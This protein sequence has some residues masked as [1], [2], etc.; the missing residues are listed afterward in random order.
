MTRTRFISR[1]KR[2]HHPESGQANI[3]VLLALGIF[4]LAFIGLAVDYSFL[5]FHRQRAQTAADAA[6]QAGAMDMLVNATNDTSLG[7]FPSPI[8]DFDCASVPDAAPCKYAALNGH[9]STTLSP[10]V[11][12][13]L[14][15]VSFPASVDGITTPPSVL[16]PT[17]FIKVNVQDAAPVYFSS[18]ITGNRVQNVGATA[19][20]GLVQSQSPIPII[21]L[22]PT[23]Q[24]SF[25]VSGSA[26][27]KIVGGPTKSVQVNSGNQSCAAATNGSSNSC[28][29]NGTIDLSQ[30]GPDFNGSAF[31]VFG[32]PTTAPK[33]FTGASWSQASPINDPF[34]RVPAPDLN[35]LPVPP[36]NGTH[37]N[38]HEHGCPDNKGCTWYEAG[39]YSVPIAVKGVT[40]IFVPGVYYIKPLSYASATGGNLCG[41][42]GSGCTAGGGGSCRADF[43]VDANGVV[44]PSNDAG[45]GSKGVVFYLSGA[46][47]STGYGSVV[48]TS[49][50]G[51]GGS[52]QASCPATGTRC[53]ESFPATSLSCD[54][55]APSSK[56]SM[57]S[58]VNGNVLMGQCT[59]GG[60]YVGAGNSDTV[61]TSSNGVRGILFFQDRAN[62]DQNGQGNMQGGGGL[63]I[64]GTIYAHNCTHTPCSPPADYNAFFDL[65]GTPG[66]GTFLLGEIVAD[67]L[68]EAGNGSISMQ[69]NPKSILNILKAELLQ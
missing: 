57:P 19:T 64:S 26:S 39:V 17:P 51:S 10:G 67:Q 35:S 56:L 31:G 18:L 66:S 23:C 2:N 16:A 24:H 61:D 45:D 43:L 33:N 50:A 62:S 46:G 53:I 60:T 9:T 7:A 63:A 47:G 59:A 36:Q 25:Q 28:D 22:H 58:L 54:G 21:V 55:S 42:A 8:A 37:V 11:A 13:S 40:A 12:G 41:S 3:F 34:A 32:Q 4:F 6:C 68:I 5:W 65:Q 44:R 1:G 52:A 30:G 38:F 15:R 69:L 20:C 49:S 48:F 27:L 14:V 29:G